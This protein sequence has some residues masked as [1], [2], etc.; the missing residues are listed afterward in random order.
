MFKGISSKFSEKIRISNYNTIF[1]NITLYFGFIG[2]PLN[3][4]ENFGEIWVSV[5]KYT[6]YNKRL[7]LWRWEFDT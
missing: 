3:A 2:T 6:I 1:P 5:G 7:G 4:V